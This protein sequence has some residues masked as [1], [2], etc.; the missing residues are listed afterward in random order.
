[1][2]RV[3]I[4]GQVYEYDETRLM[5]TEAIALQKATGFRPPEF[6]EELKKGDAI[7]LTGLVWLIL[8]RNG[9]K[10]K[11]DELE[12]DLAAIDVEQLEDAPPAN[13]T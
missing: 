3:T 11:F 4:D 5:N 10:G 2:M 12:F 13:P 8:R 6:A 1:M 7:A 9:D